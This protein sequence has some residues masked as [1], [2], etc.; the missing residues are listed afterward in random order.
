MTEEK[1]E[2]Y[3]IK[4]SAGRRTY[5]F[6]VKESSEGTIYLVISESAKK[7]ESFIHHRVMIFQEHLEEFIEGFKAAVEL[8]GKSYKP[9]I[10]K[11]E[12][13]R[14]KYPNAYRA[15]TKDD[16][17]QLQKGHSEG[18]SVDELAKILG[19]QNGAIK[20][21]LRKLGLL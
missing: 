11:Y 10:D 16:I 19:R 12:R 8:A 13:I 2:I 1:R 21:K 5:F 17:H 7:E 18:R 14:R 20:S 4:V 15:W 3:S 9:E 6:D